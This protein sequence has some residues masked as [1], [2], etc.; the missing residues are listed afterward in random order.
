MA[1]LG[2]IPEVAHY[3]TGTSFVGPLPDKCNDG[4]KHP[5]PIEDVGFD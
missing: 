4:E 3:H 1:S 2:Y 5:L